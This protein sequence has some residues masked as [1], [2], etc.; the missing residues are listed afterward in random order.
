MTT[1]D[2][3]DERADLRYDLNKPVPE[4][5]HNK[6]Q[7]VADIGCIEH[8]FDTRQVFQNYF[9]MVKVGGLFF[10]TTPVSGYIFH[11]FHMFSTEL[12]RDVLRINGFEKC[13]EQYSTRWG[14][15]VQSA[16]EG[17]VLIWIAAKKVMETNEL[18]IPQQRRYV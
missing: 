7:V 8:M 5:E 16:I 14:L 2:Y 3:F 10:L 4:T 15:P 11:G 13:M 9:D 17:D 1:I 18:V 6:Y 12:I